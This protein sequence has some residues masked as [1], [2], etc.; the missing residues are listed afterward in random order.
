MAKK[1]RTNVEVDESL[2]HS[3][4][5]GDIPSMRQE[6]ET[7]PED[8]S[9]AAPGRQ[10]EESAVSRPRK[11][12]EQKGYGDTFLERLA[13]MPRKQTYI[14]IDMYDKLSELLPV[15]AR[16]IS[17]PTFLENLLNHHFDTYRD[18]INELYSGKTQ[19]KF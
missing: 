6:S 14:S 9:E 7:P 11:R 12:R 2:I 18:E 8:K 17:I 15:I 3:M 13:P 4:M 1:E 10:D 16:G 19:K 5:E